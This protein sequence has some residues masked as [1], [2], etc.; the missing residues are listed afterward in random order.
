M[1]PSEKCQAISRTLVFTLIYLFQV[2][3]KCWAFRLVLLDSSVDSRY[4]Q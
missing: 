4:V 2:Y 1:R 3:S